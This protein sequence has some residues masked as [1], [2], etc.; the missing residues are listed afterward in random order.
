[1]VDAQAVA[2]D[3]VRGARLP[4]WWLRAAAVLA[5]VDD[6]RADGINRCADV[7]CLL[8]GFLGF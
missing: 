7:T 4:C 8:P 6:C 5:T 2:R 1:V 3:C